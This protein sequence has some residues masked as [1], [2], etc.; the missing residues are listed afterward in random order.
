[1]PHNDDRIVDLAERRARRIDLPEEPLI[2]MIRQFP[3]GAVVSAILAVFEGAD[4]AQIV[5]DLAAYRSTTS[6]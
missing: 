3:P 4:F 6:G 5:D 1:M 2:K